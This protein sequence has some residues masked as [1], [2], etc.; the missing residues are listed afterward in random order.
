M[1]LIFVFW[2]WYYYIKEGSP[3]W[4]R[5]LWTWSSPAFGLTWGRWEGLLYLDMQVCDCFSGS[6]VSLAMPLSAWSIAVMWA[7]AA[8]AWDGDLV[9]P[10][11][12]PIKD[13][14][15]PH[16]WLSHSPGLIYLSFILWLQ[17]QPSLPFCLFSKVP[18][19]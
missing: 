5:P 11:L 10:L 3:N 1:Y 15:V 17:R 12:G 9:F 13:Q 8:E 18:L 4:V 7:S 2:I 19:I 6:S 16:N 14:E